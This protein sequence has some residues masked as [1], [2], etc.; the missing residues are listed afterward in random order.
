[1]PK[2]LTDYFDT[3]TFSR[4]NIF[5]TG[6]TVDGIH[7]LLIL[8]GVDVRMQK[9]DVNIHHIYTVFQE[10]CKINRNKT[11]SLIHS[12]QTMYDNVKIT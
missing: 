3:N 6:N 4:Q 8:P 11:S 12:L 1:M 2:F 5:W 7:I 10:P 9:S